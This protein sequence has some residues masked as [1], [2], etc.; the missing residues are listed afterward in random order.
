MEV[1]PAIASGC[2][3]ELVQRHCF[4]YPPAAETLSKTKNAIHRLHSA[5]QA[6]AKIIIG[7]HFSDTEPGAQRLHARERSLDS[8]SVPLSG[9]QSLRSWFCNN[10]CYENK[11]LLVCYTEKNLNT[12]D[13]NGNLEFTRDF[14]NGFLARRLIRRCVSRNL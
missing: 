1:N 11:K 14:A 2:A 12:F 4:V 8:H 9:V 13:F 6:A 5:A 7:R 3:G 10:S